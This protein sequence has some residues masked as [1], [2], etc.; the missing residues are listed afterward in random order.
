[1]QKSATS[2]RLGITPK[3]QQISCIGRKDRLHFSYRTS[4]NSPKEPQ[5]VEAL[6]NY[7]KESQENQLKVILARPPAASSND[8]DPV[9]F[10]LEPRVEH[11]QRHL[12]ALLR[13][14][15]GD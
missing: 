14:G 3:D 1:L 4:P 12:V 6:K 15:D 7:T 2:Q 13:T 9:P 11:V 8:L 5:K 10:A